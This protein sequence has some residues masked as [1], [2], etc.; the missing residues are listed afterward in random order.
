VVVG[1]LLPV[2]PLAKILGFT[3]LPGGFFVFLAVSTVTY[4]L[5]VELAKQLLFSKITAKIAPQQ[6]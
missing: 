3:R 4:L 5:L 6:G 1:L 2:S